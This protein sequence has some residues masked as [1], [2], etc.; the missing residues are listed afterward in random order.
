VRVEQTS[1]HIDTW[2]SWEPYSAEASHNIKLTIVSKS[3]S[4]LSQQ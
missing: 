2:R 4:G 1:T 3:I